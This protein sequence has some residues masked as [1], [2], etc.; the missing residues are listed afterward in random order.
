MDG[1]ESTAD[2][3][4]IYFDEPSLAAAQQWLLLVLAQAS[5]EHPADLFKLF[6]R[7]TTV[8]R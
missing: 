3:R 2:P 8:C 1:L 6:K 7:D 4:D 5:K